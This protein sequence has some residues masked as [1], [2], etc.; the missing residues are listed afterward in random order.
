MLR[1]NE[2]KTDVL[3]KTLE[4]GWSCIE[5][6]SFFLVAKYISQRCN[7]KRLSP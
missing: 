2:I 4:F 6:F 3:D 1:K 5:T 7:T